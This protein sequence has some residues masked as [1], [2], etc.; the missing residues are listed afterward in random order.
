MPH[1]LIVEPNPNGHRFQAVG[2]VARLAGRDGGVTLMTSAGGGSSAEY[3]VFLRDLDLAVVEA[4]TSDVPPTAE[5]AARIA[6]YCREHDVRRVVVMDGDIALKSWWRHARRAYASL[7]R[8]PR[9]IF[10]LTRYPARLEWDDLP[11]WKVRIAKGV[12][13]ALGRLTR[14]I[15]RASGFAGR[16]EKARGWLVKRARDPAI[17]ATH[18][19]D[20]VALRA[21]LG[22]PDRPL[23]GV[24]GGINV[25]KNPQ[26]VFEAVER[27][28]DDVGLVLAGPF[29]PDVREW[30]AGLAPERRARIVEADGFLDDLV[31]DKYL[32]AS[33]VVALVMTL[34]GP[35]GIQGKAL[36]AGVP[37]V[38]AGSRTRER[39]LVA[40]GSGVSVE[41]GVEP[42]AAAIRDVLARPPAIA[43]DFELP[44]YESFSAT[45]L[46]V[47]P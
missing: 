40:A 35:S 24:F 38:S 47:R 21:E 37:V 46:G 43:D 39:E 14:T 13:L 2:G 19:R 36:A 6:E 28:G 25:R 27:A 33:D 5:F 7:P 31:L 41:V 18:S 3:G 34:E 15:D 23:V 42:V 26:L 29:A 11:H 1:T 22:L 4:F 30:L 16:E 44:T 9:T 20:R 10:F 32:A 12:L 45:I 17:C 8:R